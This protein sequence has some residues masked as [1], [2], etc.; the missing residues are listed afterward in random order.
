MTR[1]QRNLHHEISKK[2][3]MHFVYMLFFEFGEHV[4]VKVGESMTPYRRAK[5]IAC[6]APFVLKQAVFAHAGV[7]SKALSFERMVKAAMRDHS[8]RGEWYAFRRE[9]AADFRAKI[10]YL[11][12]KAV[13]YA[14]QWTKIDMQELRADLAA[15]NAKK[16]GK[17]AV[18]VRD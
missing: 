17:D 9:D 10:N 2:N 8:T 12:A 13:G 4:I 14:L 7:K 6:Q 16:W 11:Y 1:H 3:D 15:W 5:E 18:D